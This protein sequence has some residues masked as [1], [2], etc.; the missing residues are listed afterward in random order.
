[1]FPVSI[2]N[3]L[4]ICQEEVHIEVISLMLFWSNGI[5]I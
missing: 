1:M 2:L 5:A 3:K 4:E